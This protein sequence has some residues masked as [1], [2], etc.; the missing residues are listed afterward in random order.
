MRVTVGASAVLGVIVTAVTVAVAQPPVT[1][2]AAVFKA[3]QAL[4]PSE[5]PAVARGAGADFPTAPYLPS[6]PVPQTLGSTRASGEP[7]WL[8]GRG[9]E[10]P[11]RG[12]DGSE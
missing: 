3:P 9:S 10:R 1:E 4:P 12:G 5:L 8:S 2:R 11:P 7:A 6:T